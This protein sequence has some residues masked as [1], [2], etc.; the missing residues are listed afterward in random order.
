VNVLIVD[1]VADGADISNNSET[2]FEA[3]AWDTAVGTT[4]GDGII[5]VN[6]WFTF[7]G[8]PIP[9]LPDAGSPEV[10]LA[11][12]YCAFT[13]GGTCSTINGH[14]GVG[15]FSS[16]PFGTYTMYVQAEGVSGFS[17]IITRTFNIIP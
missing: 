16:L 15:T 8:G 2:K 4:N 6:F 11:V 9:P 13:G 14:Y 1:P 7:A 3:Q 5:N 10:Q 17:G 12:R